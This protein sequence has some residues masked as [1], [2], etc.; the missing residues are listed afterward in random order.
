MFNHSSCL[1]LQPSHSF[2]SLITNP[3]IFF[4]VEFIHL[5]HSSPF[6]HAH[7][8]PSFHRV[9]HLITL[10]ISLRYTSYPSPHSPN[11]SIFSK[12][13]LISCCNT[14]HPIFTPS[15]ITRNM[16]NHPFHLFS[17]SPPPSLPLSYPGIVSWISYTPSLVFSCFFHLFSENK[18]L[19]D[20]FLTIFHT[21]IPYLLFD[22]THQLSQK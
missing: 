11:L 5:P 18:V 15:V 8:L 22:L 20:F 9:A 16:C 21:S 1:L 17:Y 13:S 2:L 12:V 4:I 6:P 19:I 14:P 7:P 10:S 3:P